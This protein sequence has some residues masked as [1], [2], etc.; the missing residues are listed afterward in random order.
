[1]MINGKYNTYFSYL[2]CE[3]VCLVAIL[4]E[5]LVLFLRLL[6]VIEF[7]YVVVIHLFVDA[8]LALRVH[9]I[10]GREQFILT[11]DFFD[12]V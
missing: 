6:L 1:M 5:H 4:N 10:V 12:H 9:P 11:N 7:D 2:I 8:A 3:T